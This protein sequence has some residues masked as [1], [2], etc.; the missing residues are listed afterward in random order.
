LLRT[1][2]GPLPQRSVFNLYG[3]WVAHFPWEPPEAT[4]QELQAIIADLNRRGM[5]IGFEASPLVATDEC[6][7]G[8]EGCFGPE[9]GLRIVNRLKQLGATVSYV[10][11]DEPFAFGHIYDGPQ[12]CRW[13]PEKIAQQVQDYIRAIQSVIPTPLLVI[14]AAVGRCESKNSWG[15]WIPTCGDRSHL[16]FIHLDPDYS[17]R[18]AHRS[19][20]ARGRRGRGIEFGIFYLGDSGMRRTPNGW[21]KP[22]SARVYET[23][24]AADRITSNSILA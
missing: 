20:T 13:P 5:A 6:G 9:E 21:T 22:L 14:T 7:Q 12:A 10:S 8:I 16:P 3:G 24:M 2:P 15:G 17:R 11:L 18:L 23:V 19:E 1:R 4:D